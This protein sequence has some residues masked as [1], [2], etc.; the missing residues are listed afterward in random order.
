LILL[1]SA[2]GHDTT[3]AVTNFAVINHIP[4]IFIQSIGFYSRFEITLPPTFPIVDTHPD[5]ASTTDLRLLTPWPELSKFAAERTKDLEGQS[6]HE[7]GHIPYLLLL[8]YYLEKWKEQHGGNAPGNYM[9]KSEFRK[10][11][12]K[13][14]RTNNAEGVEENYDEAIAAVLKTITQHS[15]NSNVKDVFQA[16]E[17]IQLHPKVFL[18]SAFLVVVP[19]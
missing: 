9:E 6:D 11:V 2:A 4:L 1:S 5:P 18:S 3:Q 13:G 14:A 8:L 15:L 19:N 12:Q 17:C 16:P 10:L 7:H